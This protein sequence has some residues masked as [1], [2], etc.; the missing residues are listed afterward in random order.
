[1]N[2]KILIFCLILI[3]ILVAR[4]VF[5]YQNREVYQDK[6]QVNFQT[7]ILSE[8]Q[9]VVSR[10]SL[11]AN[12]PNGERVY[13]TVSIDSSFN[14]GDDLNISGTLKKSLLKDG[15]SIWTISYPKIEVRESWFALKF[16]SSIRQKIISLFERTLS[17]TSSSLLLGIVFGIKEQM[18]SD[19]LRELRIVGVLHVIAASGMNV[20][21][22]GGFLSA[23][24]SFFLKR[25]IALTLSILGIIFYAVLAG[26]EPSIIRASIMGGLVFTSQILGRQNSAPYALGLSAF[27]M[28]FVSPILISD[29]GFQLSFVATAGLL[30]IR[31]VFDR[32]RLKPL[33]EKSIVGEDIATTISAQIATF[34]ILLA[35][36][37]AYSLWSILVNALVLWTVPIL[38]ILGGIG[39]VVGFFSVFLGEIFIFL[40]LPFLLYFEKIVSIFGK[41]SALLNLQS[42]PWQISVGY[43]SIILALIFFVRAKNR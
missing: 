40:C 9:V 35:N 24:F 1:M 42:V 23:L 12:L 38:M 13:V 26:L 3:I 2:R 22:V 17:Q 11:S 15:R 41:N 19:F 7:K 32:G 36:F 8:P 28:L 27:L 34:P 37:G 4:F 5:F 31:P 10:Q 33:I 30:Y 39:A 6:Q 29:V 14:Y 18:S 25:Q 16:I 43:Y 21:M 20:V